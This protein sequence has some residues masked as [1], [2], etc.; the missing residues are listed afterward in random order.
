MTKEEILKFINDTP[1][2][3]S[4]LYDLNLL[5]EQTLNDPQ[6]YLRTCVITQLM[7]ENKSILEDR[8]NRLE[9]KAGYNGCVH[10][11]QLIRSMNPVE[12]EPLQWT[13]ALGPF[14]LAKEMFTGNTIDEA[15]DKAD[16]FYYGT[17]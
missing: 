3:L 12:G 4:L 13:L 8:L 17:N 7:K 16:R 1:E 6:N 15:L 5:P 9:K 2:L 14:H 11:T 10:G